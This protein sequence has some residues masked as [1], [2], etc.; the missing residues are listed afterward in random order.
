MYVVTVCPLFTLVRP[1][2]LLDGLA[3]LPPTS[4]LAGKI[5]HLDNCGHI[6][7]FE[8]YTHDLQA[9]LATTPCLQI[10]F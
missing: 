2:A 9:V 5:Y 6:L 3:K 4:P 8:D 7:L 1:L 10:G